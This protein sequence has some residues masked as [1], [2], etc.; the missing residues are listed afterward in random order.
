MI[1]VDID[2]DGDLDLVVSHVNQPSAILENN[3]TTDSDWYQLEL[4]GTRSNRDAI[5]SQVVLSTDKGKRLR[6]ICGGGSYLSQGPYSVHFGVPKGEKLEACEITWP[7]GER[8]RIEA[9]APN[10]KHTII[11]PFLVGASVSSR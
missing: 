3:R 11:E 5:G 1:A 6:L 10:Q 2:C 7:D 4:K 9:L 8:Q